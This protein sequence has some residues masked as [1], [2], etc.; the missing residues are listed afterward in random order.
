MTGI[1]HYALSKRQLCLHRGVLVNSNMTITQKHDTQSAKYKRATR[2]HRN[3]TQ[4]HSKN[5][6][7]YHKPTTAYNRKKRVDFDV[8]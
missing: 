2:R 3:L 6:G 7:Y 1:Y 5:V 8:R 4:K